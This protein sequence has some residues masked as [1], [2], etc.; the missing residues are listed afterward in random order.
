MPPQLLIISVI[1]ILGAWFLLGEKRSFLEKLI[2]L[3][4]LL[5]VY[6]A[7]RLMS[8]A[9]PQDL[10]IPFREGLKITF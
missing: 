9:T 2:L 5:F 6:I 3:L 1:L 4:G 7:Y 10:L 8:G